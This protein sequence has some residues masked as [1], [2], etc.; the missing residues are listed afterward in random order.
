MLFPASIVPTARPHGIGAPIIDESMT[1]RFRTGASLAGQTVSLSLPPLTPAQVSDL[2][3]HWETDQLEGAFSLPAATVW[4]G[5]SS[6]PPVMW[7]YT[8]PPTFRRMPGGR[9]EVTGLDLMAA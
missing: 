6:P 3:A 1:H 5:R 2:R 8:R 7:R 9:Y 4:L